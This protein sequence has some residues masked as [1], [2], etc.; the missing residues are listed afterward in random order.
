M[1]LILSFIGSEGSVHALSTRLQC[2]FWLDA[3]ASREQKSR[4][5]EV[6]FIKVRQR[7]SSEGIYRLPGLAAGKIKLKLTARLR[8]IHRQNFMT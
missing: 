3:E 8:L 2:S 6:E 7:D 1:H 5:A 4:Q